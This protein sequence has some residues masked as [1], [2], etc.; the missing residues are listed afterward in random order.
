MNL[1]FIHC[2]NTVTALSHVQEATRSRQVT[3]VSCINIFN[4]LNLI[5]RHSLWVASWG[6]RCDFFFPCILVWTQITWVLAWWQSSINVSRCALQT[7]WA[8]MPRAAFPVFLDLACACFTFVHCWQRAAVTVGYY[9]C[10]I[11][12]CFRNIFPHIHDIFYP[13]HKS[14]QMYDS[15]SPRYKQLPSCLPNRPNDFATNIY[16]HRGWQYQAD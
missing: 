16:N 12:I 14:V 6:K 8:G 2:I 1:I 10:N 9:G 5:K 3:P 11:L 7:R 4:F 13:L 15:T